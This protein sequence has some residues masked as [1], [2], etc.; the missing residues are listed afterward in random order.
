MDRLGGTGA[1]SVGS[2]AGVWSIAR[3]LRPTRLL[4]ISRRDSPDLLA[5]HAEMALKLLQGLARRV[6]MLVV[7]AIHAHEA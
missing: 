1:G 2:M 6:R 3:T 4:R 5:D 7:T